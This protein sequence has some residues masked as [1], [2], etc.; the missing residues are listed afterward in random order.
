ME[1]DFNSK[2]K[3]E[4]ECLVAAHYLCYS[5]EEKHCTCLYVWTMQG[6]KTQ[7]ISDSKRDLLQAIS[8]LKKKDWDMI[9]Y[10]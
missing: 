10:N 7:K 4:P 6:I 2:I 9:V 1:L 8:V 3:E 5:V